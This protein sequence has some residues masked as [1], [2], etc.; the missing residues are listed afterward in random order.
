MTTDTTASA[1]DLPALLAAAEAILPDI[2]ADPAPD[3][4]TSRDRA[5]PARRRRPRRRGA[6]RSRAGAP[7]RAATTSVIARDRRRAPRARRSCSAPT[8]TRCRSTRT[9]ASTSPPRSTGAMHACGHDTHVA[10]LLGAARLLQERRA[11]PAGPRAA[12][13][14]ARRG[15]LR[16]ARSSCSRRA[17]STRPAPTAPT[18]A[19][20]L[21]I[22]TR[23]PSRRGPR[24]AR[25]DAGLGRRDPDHGPR[26]R[27]PRLRRRT[28]RSTR[29]PSR[30]RSSS[31]C[32]RWSPG[33]STSSTR[34]SSR[35]PR[36]RA[37]TTNNIIPETVVPV[38]HDP[39]ACRRTT[40]RRGPRPASSASPRASPPRTAR[41]PRSTSRRAI[42][43]PS[44]TPAFTALVRETR[45][46]SLSATS[47]RGAAGADHGRRGLLV[48]PPAGARARWPSSARG[49]D[50]QDPA[51][52]P[53]EPLQPGRLRR[54]GDGRRRGALRRGGARS[55]LRAL[56]DLG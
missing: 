56:P 50:G 54:G 28:S 30:P 8:W 14:P 45:P 23:Y 53:A 32:R 7:A 9:P 26:P 1:L 47:G 36:S 12:D 40:A 29:S 31:P 52:A 46:R 3:P 51:T 2:I 55:A 41:R 5:S 49:R 16:R 37:G 27:R 15:G 42:R 19:L 44:T 24:P 18:G 48:R 25:A 34:P 17:C 20:A 38:R 39:H 10:M 43:S 35:S 4:S 21:H 11:R 13:V 22:C 6:P 33:G